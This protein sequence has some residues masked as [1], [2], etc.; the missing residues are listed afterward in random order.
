MVQ[1]DSLDS[2]RVHNNLND[3]TKAQIKHMKQLQNI[4]EKKKKSFLLKSHMQTSI[5]STTSVKNKGTGT[6]SRFI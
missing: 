3:T 2:F 5:S 4:W 6:Q 1:V